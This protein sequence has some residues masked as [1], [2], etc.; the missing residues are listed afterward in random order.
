MAEPK[1][2]SQEEMA[3]EI[4]NK[5]LDEFEYKG[6]TIRQWADKI[7]SGEY[8]P[9]VYGRWINEYLGYGVSRY[10]CS[11]CGSIFGEDQIVDFKH[12][13]YCADCGAQMNEIT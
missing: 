3:K 6:M 8:K 13:N 11:K 7:T 12:N 2:P 4:A 10:R 1:T 5:T 9:V